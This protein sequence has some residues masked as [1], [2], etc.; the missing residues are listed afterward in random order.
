MTVLSLIMHQKRLVAGLYRPF[1]ELTEATS[2]Q[3][4]GVSEHRLAPK[5]HPAYFTENILH[6]IDVLTPLVQL[7]VVQHLG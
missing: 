5:N 4:V 1:T 2:T 3:T 7:H 6:T